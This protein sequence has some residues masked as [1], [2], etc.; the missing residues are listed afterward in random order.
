ME[1]HQP[2]V[3]VLGYESP[4]GEDGGG[5]Y[6]WVVVGMLWFVCLFNYADRQAIYSVFPL[7]Q[8]EMKLLRRF[9]EL[10]LEPRAMLEQ[11]GVDLVLRR[12]SRNDDLDVPHCVDVNR[13]LARTPR[14]AY[15]DLDSPAAD[16]DAAHAPNVVV[17]SDDAAGRSV[18]E[19]ANDD[20]RVVPAEAERVRERDVQV[21]CVA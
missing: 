11:Q 15:W 20:A 1:Q 8:S 19:S 18:F 10:A 5:A 14:H 21:G 6:R 4:P 17:L 2:S 16:V 12:P 7:L 3:A 9:R 13:K